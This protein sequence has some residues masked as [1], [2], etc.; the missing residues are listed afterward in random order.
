M[1][2]RLTWI[3]TTLA[4]ALF[5]FIYFF[6]R[7]TPSSADKNAAPR[8]FTTLEPLRIQAV[9]ITLAGGGIVRAE[10]TNGNWFLTKPL[11]PAQQ[12]LVETFVTNVARLRRYDRIAAHEVAL[13]GQKAFGLEPAR[14]TVLVETPTN[15]IRF[16]IGGPAPLTNNIYLRVEPS[17]EVVLTQAEVL[18][19]L[20]KTTNDWERKT[21]PAR[22]NELRSYPGASRP[23]TL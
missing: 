9:E 22:A 14:A 13:Q 2:Q 18:G 6:E 1:Q 5:A 3:L 7:K 15:R 12:S 23:A 16:E 20:P 4:L 21:A 10:Q 17:A 19:S 11:Y 8:I